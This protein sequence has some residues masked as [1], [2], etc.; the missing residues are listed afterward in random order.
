[1]AGMD[2][3]QWVIVVAGMVITFVVMEMEKA[4][5]R[6]LMAMGTDTDDAEYGMFDSQPTP[7]QDISL[8]KGASHLNLTEL[9]K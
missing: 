4:L 2:A 9:S 7:N 3:M 8:P 6:Y 5:R 1:M